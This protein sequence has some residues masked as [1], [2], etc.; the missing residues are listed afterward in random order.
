[1]AT[2]PPYGCT[3]IYT[4]THARGRGMLIYFRTL[5]R[6]KK[7]KIMGGREEVERE[8]GGSI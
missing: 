2:A 3:R 4:Y 5:H 1:M 6:L 8:G 7:K